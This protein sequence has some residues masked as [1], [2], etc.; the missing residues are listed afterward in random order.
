MGSSVRW[1]DKSKYISRIVKERSPQNAGL[2]V[3]TLASMNRLANQPI[4]FLP[5]TRA[6]PGVG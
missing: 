6:K 1:N 3:G 2:M 5:E 4:N